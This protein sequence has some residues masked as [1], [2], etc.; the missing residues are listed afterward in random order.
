MTRK[1][2]RIVGVVV[3]SFAVQWAI[4]NVTVMF[5]ESVRMSGHYVGLW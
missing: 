5:G 3:A 4:A 1:I 2:G